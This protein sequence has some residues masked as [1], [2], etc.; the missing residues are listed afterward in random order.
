MCSR[1]YHGGLENPNLKI[2]DWTIAEF[3]KVFYPDLLKQLEGIYFCGNFGDPIINDD[4]LLMCE[5]CSSI[6]PKLQVRIHTNGSA[7]SSNWWKNL[8]KVLPK[9]HFVIFG[10]DGL[11]DTHHLYRIG[12]SFK[13]ILKNAKIFINEGGTAEWVFIK[14]KHN[15]HQVEEARQLAEQYG[16][17]MFT[18]KNSTRFLE[19]K[20]PVYDNQGSTKYY[21]EPPS[22]N[23]VILITPSMIGKFKDWV[24]S[25]EINCYVQNNKELYFDAHKKVFPCCFL[26]SAPYNYY[27]SQSEISAIRTQ[28]K[29]QYTELVESLGGIDKL[30]LLKNNLRDIIDSLEWQN[31]WEE[32][33]TSKKLI[34]CARTCGNSDLDNISKPKDQFIERTSFE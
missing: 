10:I 4:L 31:S 11:E 28:I 8:F 12:T 1:N 30:D 21:L 5:Y 17:K 18:V 15:E 6:N 26:A 7:R 16:F 33:W 20:F 2:S 29:K 19:P 14:F 25:A 23:R 22:D 9:N 3:K 13:N 24:D 34:T 27:N 32:Y